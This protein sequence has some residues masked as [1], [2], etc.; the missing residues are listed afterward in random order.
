MGLIPCGWAESPVPLTLLDQVRNLPP[1]TAAKELPF[2]VQGIVSYCDPEWNVLFIQDK[3]A[4]IFIEYT[5]SKDSIP[6]QRGQL[7]D[8][9][10]TTTNGSVHCNLKARQLHVLETKPMPP[11]LQLGEAQVLNDD[12]E[13]RWV[14]MSGWVATLGVLGNRITLELVVQPGI[15]V[16]VVIP[17]LG[18]ADAENFRGC[19]VEVPG[20]IALKLARRKATGKYLLFANAASEVR[21]LRF[22]PVVS[23]GE[24][25]N[26]KNQPSATEPLMVSGRMEGTNTNSLVLADE[27]YSIRVELSQPRNFP[28]RVPVTVFGYPTYEDQ[29]LVLTKAVVKEAVQERLQSQPSMPAGPNAKLPEL[30]RVTQV[31][32]LSSREASQGYPVRVVGTVT[33]SDPKNFE[34]YIQDDSAGIYINLNRNDILLAS[35]QKVEITG[36][37]GPGDYAPVIH[38]TEVR[39]LGEG[40]L[41]E[42]RVSTFPMMLTGVEDSQWISL[43][44]VIRGQI[45]VNNVPF[46]LMATGDALV[47]LRLPDA[48]KPSAIA[49]C[50]DAA[51]EVHGVCKTIVNERR[52]LEGVE[53][54]VPDWTQIEIKESPPDDPFK[55]TTHP[56]NELSQFHSGNSGLHRTRLQGLVTLRQPNGSFFLEDDSGGIRVEPR[57]PLPDQLTNQCVEVVGFPATVDGLP[58]LQ[59]AMYRPLNELK[60]LAPKELMA[61]SPLNEELHAAL[62]WMDCR[63]L[64]HFE[65]RR[66]ERLTVQ[67]GSSV[68]D[69]FLQKTSEEARLGKIPIGSVLRLTGVYL[70]RLDEARKVQSFQM[71]LRSPGD[72][73]V[74][75]RPAWWTSSHVYWV[76]GGGFGVLLMAVAWIGLLHTQ[77]N[78]RTHELRAEIEERKR[79]EVQLRQAQKMEAIGQLAGGVAHDFNNILL[80]ILL[81]LGLLQDSSDLPVD[82]RLSLQELEKEANRAA[83][84]T[85]QLLL[86][87]RR[88]VMIVK[89][90]VLN[91]VVSNLLQMLRRLL[92]EHIQL[93]FRCEC[94][95]HRIE[96]DAGM[97]EQVVV[98]LC[99]NARDAMPK[100]GNLTIHCKG[101]VF[102]ADAAR[103]NPEARPGQ[104]VCL[105]VTDTGVGMDEQTLK[106]VFEPFFTTKGVGKGTGLGL[107][108]VYGIVKQHDGW[109]EVESVL[110]QG[111]TFR[112]L[113]PATLSK[114]DL[115][116]S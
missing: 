35:G 57:D 54:H 48:G 37:S 11:A 70:A 109:V 3:S 100:G 44:G 114:K 110:G 107:A 32:S 94:S 83:T 21:K 2:H 116:V 23:V 92:G 99:V 80:A 76:L 77:V 56:I 6:L 42:P 29:V 89:P 19:L 91:E 101:V 36:F 20:V 63:V 4:P 22:L 75:S 93:T 43:Q 9:E 50:I 73:T 86:F 111:T 59:E 49:K 104:F 34:Q 98:N 10:G 64:D 12:Y 60:S 62:V 72:V 85:R 15:I 40:S 74:L 28:L 68:V 16:S 13:G 38:A 51:V 95:G 96:A 81:H 113:L 58:V 103:H 112:V 102:D 69:A 84:L 87:G 26:R 31:R 18:L 33:Y 78:Q 5:P 8:V 30:T 61:E 105:S 25:M 27:A 41:P 45:V 53:L 88:Q 17:G 14:R 1:K 90:L 7:V 66:D 24:L 46:L 52:R 71:L 82:L 108:T 55:L 39:V 65:S 47:K 97:M 106:R 79:L 115:Q 67:L